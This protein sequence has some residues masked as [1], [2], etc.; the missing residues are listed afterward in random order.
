[1]SEET[2]PVEAGV[3]PPGDLNPRRD[4]PLDF[5]DADY[6]E[7]SPADYR[8]LGF[9]S[10]LEVHQQL[11]TRS[12]L[13]CRCP[14]GRSVR[15]YEAEVLRHMRP[16]LS[17][18]GEYDGTALM[19][20]KTRKEIVYR[21]ERESVCTYEMDDTP[22]FEIDEEAVRI[23][24]EI[25]LLLNL[26]LV[27]ELHVMRKQYLDGSI[28]TGFQ[29]TA[30]VG[31]GGVIPFQVP[32]LGVNRELRIRQLSLEEDSCREVS[33]IGHRIVFRTD[34]LGTPLTETVTEPELLTPLELQAAA[35]LLARVARATGKV[36]R[37][38][39][40]ARQDVNV[41]VAGGRRIE[42]KGVD[43]HRGLP[44]LVHIEA[45]RQLNLLRIRAELRRR[46]VEAAMPAVPDA[47]RPWEVSAD[48]VDAGAVMGCCGYA[49]IDDALERGEMVVAVR[50]P[51]F[52]GLL[53]HRTQ[54]GVTFAREFADRVR[55]IA[56]PVHRPFMIHS[57]IGDYG[58]D[59]GRWGVLRKRLGAESGDAVIV[60]WAVEED[61]ATAVRELFIRARDALAGVP[62]ETRQAFRD[63][64]NGF[65][66]ILPGPDRMYPD[67][68][69]PP[70][71]ISDALVAEIRERV[72]ETPWARVERYLGLG[73]DH[74]AARRLAA[75]PWADLF[76]ALGP[77][78]GDTA[79]RLAAAFE[80]RIPYHS[81]RGALRAPPDAERLRPVV[82]AIVTGEVR[83]EAID[84]VLDALIERADVPVDEVLA[85][86]RSRPADR[87]E[88]D[89]VL[90][91][92]AA[93]AGALAGRPLE[94]AIRW[95][96]GEVMP[97]FLGR[98]DP[99]LV[100]AR[101]AGALKQALLE[102]GA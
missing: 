69:T 97:R 60:V 78:A 91:E 81:R 2:K 67:T 87:E 4:P 96:M 51:G 22:P 10:G 39:G 36:R 94:T 15:D 75:A 95:G 66:R 46:G 54:P 56:C 68:D 44:R 19:E 3:R 21:L 72:P 52:A 28:P 83:P 6:G 42:L 102:I 12:K 99:S 43:N 16:T 73:L 48:V 85:P 70:L 9:M 32:E 93:D 86:F 53:N 80:K 77:P 27:S 18:L 98:L 59:S 63:G 20:F 65:E 26:N 62:A 38:P 71:P 45:F 47:D 41:S 92:L 30:M 40:A 11:L 8:V 74:A 25:A 35:R 23:A 55:V 89:C 29:R 13:F 33:D 79:R 84:P 37:G 101:L 61:A 1:M 7:L 76:D 49:P 5:P 100:R 58:L 88:L 24:I 64:R 50:L 34:R 90:A 82:G 17:E 57:D 31:L 14:A